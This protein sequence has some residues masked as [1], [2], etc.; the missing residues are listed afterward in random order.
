MG[1]I[2]CRAWMYL[3]ECEGIEAFG[4]HFA[5]VVAARVVSVEPIS[6]GKNKV[7]RIDA[8]A[9]RTATVLCG[10]PNVRVGMI[11]AWVPPGTSLQGRMI[12][13]ALIDGVESEGMLASGDELGINRDHS[14]LL[15]LTGVEPGSRCRI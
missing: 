13:R 5:Q 8:G 15:E 14:G 4:A 9:D 10:A 11:A 1:K 6:K 2:R 3:G 7:V 12:G